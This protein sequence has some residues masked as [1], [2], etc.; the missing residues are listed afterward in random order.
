[1]RH[2]QKLFALSLIFASAS[3]NSWAVAVPKR[4]DDKPAAP[5]EKIVLQRVPGKSPEES[6]ACIQVADGFRIELAAA[7]PNVID[8]VAIDFDEAGRMYVVEMRD[9]SEQDKARLGRI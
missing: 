8:P 5:R 6:L 3:I 2:Y 1:M 7:E 9:Y 4:A